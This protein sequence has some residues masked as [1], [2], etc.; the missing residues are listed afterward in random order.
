[1][2]AVMYVNEELLCSFIIIKPESKKTATMKS[3]KNRPGTPPK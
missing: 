2:G 1:M 3:S